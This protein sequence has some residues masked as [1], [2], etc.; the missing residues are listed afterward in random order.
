MFIFTEKERILNLRSFRQISIITI[1]FLLM[2]LIKPASAQLMNLHELPE[3]E[4][5]FSLDMFI[6]IV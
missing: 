4:L 2:L 6:I 5:A 3:G 1:A